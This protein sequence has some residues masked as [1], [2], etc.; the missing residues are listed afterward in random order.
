MLDWER[1]RESEF[2]SGICK[3]TLATY[4]ASGPALPWVG[5]L[6]EIGDNYVGTCAFKSPPDANGVE[7]AYFTFPEHEGKG[8]AKHMASE[9]VTIARQ[10]GVSTVRAQTLP[11]ANTS[12]RILERLGFHRTGSVVHP[13]DGEEWEWKLG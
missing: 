11:E 4:G 10:N 3:S 5:Y 9:L 1:I 13:E 7:I 8:I 12:T 6:A 2:L